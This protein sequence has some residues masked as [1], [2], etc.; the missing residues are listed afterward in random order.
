MIRQSSLEITP[1]EDEEGEEK[2]DENEDDEC[3]S[4][5]KM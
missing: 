1:K 3:R 4:V 2:E 5:M